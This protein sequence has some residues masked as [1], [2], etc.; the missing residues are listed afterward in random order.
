MTAATSGDVAPWR[1]AFELAQHASGI[2]YALRV[3]AK[4]QQQQITELRKLLEYHGDVVGMPND[5]IPF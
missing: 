3:V 1:R 4:S 5:D 2:Q